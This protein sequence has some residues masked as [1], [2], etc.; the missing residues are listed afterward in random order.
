MGETLRCRK[1]PRRSSNNVSSKLGS[2]CGVGSGWIS[3]ESDLGTHPCRCEYDRPDPDWRRPA[4][5][6]G[7]VCS[8]MRLDAR[9][10]FIRPHCPWQHG[11]VHRFRRPF[12]PRGPTTSLYQRRRQRGA[13]PRWMLGPFVTHER[14]SPAPVSSRREPASRQRSRRRILRHRPATGGR[15]QV[16][17]RG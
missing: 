5:P 2:G 7:R 17:R 1:A 6:R 11:N 3:D 10:V 4:S 14:S 8:E 12:K 9:Q 15:R 13:T 16:I